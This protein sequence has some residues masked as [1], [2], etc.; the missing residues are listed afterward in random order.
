MDIKQVFEDSRILMLEEDIARINEYCKYSNK[1]KHVMKHLLEER[2]NVLW[3]LNVYDDETKQLLIDFNEAL[4]EVCMQ[5]YCQTMT[6]F[7]EHLHL[8]GLL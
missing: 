7:Q 8:C 3:H 5:L 4:R 6:V 1:E 2:R